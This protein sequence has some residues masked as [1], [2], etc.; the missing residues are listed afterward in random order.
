MAWLGV[1]M[2]VTLAAAPPA[3]QPIARENLAWWAARHQQKVAAARAGG[4]DLVLLGDSITQRWEAPAY[5]KAWQRFYGDRRVLN[6]GFKGDATSHLLW[7]IQHG[8]LDGLQPKA[9][10]ILIGANNLGRLHWPA[11]ADVAGII[12]VV[13]ATRARLPGCGILLLS[14]L[15]SDRG[16]WV[17]ATTAAINRALAARY[18]SGAVAGVRYLDVAALFQHSDGTTDVSQ[19]ADP[20]QSPPEPAL[21]PSPAGLARL[22]SAIEPALAAMLGDRVHG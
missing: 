9:A 1:A 8:E 13:E 17:A 20:A 10:V 21:H 11:A 5:R 2:A 12:A 15:P 7:R 4:I 19:F 22:A 14:V 6:L 18:A 16:T 3:A